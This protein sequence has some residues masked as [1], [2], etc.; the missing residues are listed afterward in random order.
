MKTKGYFFGLPVMLL[1][2]GLV[3]AASLTLAGCGEEEEEKS[4]TVSGEA[5]VGA[6][7]TATF[8]GFTPDADDIW[9]NSANTADGEGSNLSRD[10]GSTTFTITTSDVGDYIWVYAD[11]VESNRIGPVTN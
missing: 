6:T 10:H 3:L 2:L 8:S 11:R 9:W 4:I 7:L 5:K 1:A